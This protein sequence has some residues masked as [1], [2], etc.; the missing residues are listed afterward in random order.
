MSGQAEFCKL[1]RRRTPAENIDRYSFYSVG[2]MKKRIAARRERMKNILLNH[3]PRTRK[4]RYA[5]M[6]KEMSPA[7]KNTYQYGCSISTRLE[8]PS[9]ASD[10]KNGS[11]QHG[12]ERNDKIAPRNDQPAEADNTRAEIL[13]RFSMSLIKKLRHLNVPRR[14]RSTFCFSNHSCH[15]DVFSCF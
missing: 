6:A 14:I 8:L 4:V 11:E 12:L 15:R 2:R 7:E 10:R 9:P 1:N 13:V 5:E 3:A